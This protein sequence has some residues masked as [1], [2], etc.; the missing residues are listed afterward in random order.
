M[1]EDKKK[2]TVKRE[3]KGVSGGD[4]REK[5]KKNQKQDIKKLQTIIK[6]GKRKIASLKKKVKS[7]NTDEGEEN[8]KGNDDAAN[9]FGGKRTKSK[10]E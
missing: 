1:E 8:I 4:K 3:R 9:Q 7:G 2:V 6:K 10:K 5:G